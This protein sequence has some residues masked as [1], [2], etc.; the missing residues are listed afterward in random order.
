MTTAAQDVARTLKTLGIRQVFALCADQ[1]NSLLEAFVT[2]GIAVVSARQE[3]AAVHMA[4]GWSRATG[5]PGV[6][7][8]GGGPG[9]VNAV[10]GIAVSQSAATPVLVIGGQP[11]LHTR[12][13]NGHQI[14]YQAD[15][16]RTLTKWSQEVMSPAT[17]SE[18][19]C[20][21]LGMAT[22]GKPGPVSLSIP[23][24]VFDADAESSVYRTVPHNWRRDS[25][26]CPGAASVVEAAALLNG[27]SRP[28]MIVGG[29]AWWEL[30]RAALQPLAQQLGI[31]VFT[32]ELARGLIPDDG[33][34]CFGYAHPAFSRTFR[35]LRDADLIVLVGTEMN[36][37]TGAPNR[38]WVGKDTKIV[39]L[40]RDPAQIG[41]GRATD[42][43]LL[44]SLEYS[45]HSLARGLAG[46]AR[47]RHGD[48][49]QHI[50]KTYAHH[51]KEWDELGRKHGA[52]VKG[53]I[54]PMRVCTS[55]A[56]HYSSDVRVVIDGGDFVHWPRL[57]FEAKTPGYWMDGAELGALG[58]SLPVGIGA[59][60][61]RPAGQTWVFIG[62]GGFGFYGFDL[63]TAVE[64]KLALKVIMGNDCCWGVERR[65]QRKDFGRTVAVDLPD[66]EY[67]TVARG[68]GAQA[69]LVDDPARLDEAVDAMVASEGPFV[70]NIKIPRD[71]G[72][73][74]MS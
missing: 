68:L 51:R 37:H 56:R 34:I 31:P 36:L 19:V 67:H 54:H 11:V 4:D 55:L 50:R 25:G 48:W 70:L 71:A 30:P 33:E 17:A 47:K 26:E 58:A 24:N 9:Y 73:P 5:E 62:D 52:G 46:E 65:L 23:V 7:I 14:L 13:R 63:S 40:H 45:L 44:G 27:A 10:T 3:S 74:L 72:R 12:E 57:Y 60:L 20:R 16:T 66:L 53:A 59:Q 22:A 21:G 38:G 15:I 6:A 1:T 8:V 42:A 41:I 28:M 61:G 39:Q 43:A 29:G 32:T 49:L 2:E 35:E 18:F 64:N 69:L